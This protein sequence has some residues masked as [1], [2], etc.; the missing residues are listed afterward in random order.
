MTYILYISKH[1]H[2][3]LRI[4][5]GVTIL[6]ATMPIMA[7]EVEGEAEDRPS[8]PAFESAYLIDNQSSKVYQAKTLEMVIQHRFG[9]VE[10]GITDVFGLYA[11]SNIR[12][13]FT[14]APIDRFNVGF[15]YTKNNQY[16]DL[17]GKFSIFKQ[18]KS[19]SMPVN[20]VYFGNVAVDMRDDDNFINDSDRFTF[21][22]SVIISKRFGQNLSAQVTPSVSHYN[23]VE[24][25]V[26]RTGDVKGLMKN[27]HFAVSAIARY[28]IS[29]QTAIIVGV[30][31]PITE[32]TQNNPPPNVSF[33]IEISTSSH[34][35]QVFFANFNG[36]VQQE[37]NTFNRNN[38]VDGE[39]L[40]GFNIT[41][42]WSF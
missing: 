14:Y 30:D 29:G 7:Q 2:H 41:R 23:S 5:M 13:G 31:Q 21:F 36:I 18:T 28:K 25:Y 35:F 24:A 1:I 16:L 19:G 27:N 8:R 34:A 22:H 38:Y 3:S 12:I 20:I 42:L 39:F 15:G 32:H 33:G 6:I 4:L 37:N 26:D 9:L 17:N 10:N 40:I 11:P